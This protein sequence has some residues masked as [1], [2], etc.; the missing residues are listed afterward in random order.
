MTPGRFLKI[1]ARLRMLTRRL[2][3]HEEQALLALD[4]DTTIEAGFSDY[5]HRLGEYLLRRKA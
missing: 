2:R 5:L 1:L 4:A 3:V